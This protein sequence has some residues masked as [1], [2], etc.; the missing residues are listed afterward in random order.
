MRDI[1]YITDKGYFM[2]TLVSM[3]SLI[4]S[5]KDSANKYNIYCV[6]SDLNTYEKECFSMLQTDYAR[7]ILINR[8]K[9]DLRGNNLNT[10]ISN[11]STSAVPISLLKFEIA[12]IFPD[13]DKI[14]Y[15]DGDIIIKKTIDKIFDIDLSDNYVAAVLDIGLL[16]NKNI[17]ACENPK[18]FNSG[19]MLLNLKKIR[20]YNICNI[21][22]EKKL[23]STD[24]TFM[25]Q[26]VL[27]E[28]FKG[29]TILLPLKYNCL[30]L[31]ITRARYFRGLALEKINKLYDENY[32]SWNELFNDAS[33]IHYASK[34]KPWKYR[35]G[36]GAK[37]WEYY[38][39]KTPLSDQPLTRKKLHLSLLYNLSKYKFLR[40]PSIFIWDC[41]I[42]G[43]KKAFEQDIKKIINIIKI[44]DS[45]K[46][47]TGYQPYD[48]QR[49]DYTKLCKQAISEAGYEIRQ[50][51]LTSILKCI[52][53]HKRS[54][55]LVNFNWFDEISSD[56]YLKKQWI[57]FKRKSIITML[58]ISGTKIVT[59]IHNRV[60][61]TDNKYSNTKFR[62]WLLKRSDA[63]IQLSKDTE[64][65]LQQQADSD[66]EKIKGKIFTIPHPSYLSS[67][68]EHSHSMRKTMG[69]DDSQFVVLSTGL[70]RPYKNIEI[71]IEAAKYLNK[72][73]NILFYVVGEAYD[74]EYGENLIQKVKSLD[75]IIFD[76]RFVKNEELYAL[77]EAADICLYP[78][79]VRSSLNSS[80]CL[81]CCSLGKTCIIPEIGTVHEIN[82]KDIFSYSYKNDQEHV[83]AV[84]ENIQ[85]AYIEWIDSRETFKQHGI[86]LKALVEKKYSLEETSKRYAHLYSK[87]LRK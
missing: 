8:K 23:S 10:K 22:Y 75:N 87:L 50:L 40:L 2:P 74:A 64:I 12:D 69:W 3:K 28:T 77:I 21:L 30:Y 60:P 14:L 36:T 38:Y 71:I 49:N 85:K 32:R 45:P 15:L 24:T 25:D 72:R 58:K 9:L 29:H 33:I 70:I 47:V 46:I 59:T 54:L 42:Y 48:S 17:Q 55:K 76:F 41:Q 53:H 5:A 82:S 31:G 6:Y 34:D 83:A 66:W 11:S 13:K 84:I 27:N 52:F 73:K 80:N 16:Y 26:G 86:Q 4:E 18:Y 1:V 63:V 81:L 56:S 79:N 62:L 67:I 20:E 51:N 44:E 68:H 65:I 57:T 39:N 78:Y 61:H 43:F 35:D 19:M 37:L 7:I